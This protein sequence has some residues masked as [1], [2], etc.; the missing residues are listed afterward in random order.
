MANE[1]KKVTEKVL[2]LLRFQIDKYL[3]KQGRSRREIDGDYV[4]TSS[5]GLEKPGNISPR[6]ERNNEREL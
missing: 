5:P 3:E 4:H 1:K 2:L 6:S